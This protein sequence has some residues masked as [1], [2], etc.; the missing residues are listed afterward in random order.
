MEK[1]FRLKKEARQFFSDSMAKE[2]AKKN[3]WEENNVHNNL[4][5]QVENIYVD[6]GIR[7]SENSKQLCG[8]SSNFGGTPSA[9]F[10]FTLK[11]VDIDNEQY[12]TVNIPDLMDAIQKTANK[13]FTS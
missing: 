2:I 12:R 1:L 8:W 7:T 6:Y 3:Y 13:F 9:E 5:E 10:R 11:V 4:L